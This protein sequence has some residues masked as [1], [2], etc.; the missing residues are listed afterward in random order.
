[1]RYSVVLSVVLLTACAS[2]GLA[3]GSIVVETAS[4]GQP[5]PGANCAV[6]TGAG[7]WNIVTPATFIVGD[8]RGDLRVVCNKSGYRT[9]EVLYRPLGPSNS[10]IG[11]GIGGGTGNVGVGLGFGFPISFGG[12]RYP[13]QVTVEMN[14]L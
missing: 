12:A 13:S 7:N 2:G 3:D 6:S 14:P 10:S 1:M 4:R 9:S 11:I 8:A 5:L